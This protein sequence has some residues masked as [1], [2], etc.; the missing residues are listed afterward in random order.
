MKKEEVERPVPYDQ[1][2]V[3]RVARAVPSAYPQL[4][5]ARRVSHEWVLN[6]LNDTLSTRSETRTLTHAA[7]KRGTTRGRA[8]RTERVTNGKQRVTTCQ[9]RTYLPR[10]TN[11]TKHKHTS[12][13]FVFVTVAVFLSRSTF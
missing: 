13:Y 1:V 4:S 3:P 11:G 7:P 6:C 5:G 2:V 10:G 8:T 12:L 9:T